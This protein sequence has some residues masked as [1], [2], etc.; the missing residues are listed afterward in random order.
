[1]GGQEALGHRNGENFIH[2]VFETLGLVKH[3]SLQ[4]FLG[5]TLFTDGAAPE[6][7]NL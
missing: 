1:M 5:K 3:H 6:E 4:K 2:D 7:N